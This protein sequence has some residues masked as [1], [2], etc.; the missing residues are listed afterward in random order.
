MSFIRE[1]LSSRNLKERIIMSVVLFF[2]IFFAVVIISYF[3]L[4][5]GLLKNKN[6]V[7]N[8]RPADNITI[9]TLQIFLYNLISVIIIFAASL[10]S[11]KKKNETDY[12]SVGYTVY[13][14]LISINAIVL[15]TWSF[16]IESVP[17]PL[18]SRVLN[19]FNL[20]EKAAL[21]E[22]TGQLFI[23]CALAQISVFRSCEKDTVKSNFKEIRMENKERTV[24]ISG[25]IFMLIGAIIESMAINKL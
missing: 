14:T 20:T 15:G 25:I 16:S 7:Q 1:K 12:L 18:L 21:W 9:L 6:P 8:W 13:F 3:F 17:P 23:T 10:F 11:N 4:P 24:L 22:M 2:V 5:E 19:I